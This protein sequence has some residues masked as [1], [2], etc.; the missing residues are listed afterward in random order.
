MTLVHARYGYRLHWQIWMKVAF[1]QICQCHGFFTQPDSQYYTSI[2]TVIMHSGSSSSCI[3]LRCKL[4]CHSDVIEP[5]GGSSSLF[6]DSVCSFM[7]SQ[8][9]ATII[10]EHYGVRYYDEGANCQ[11]VEFQELFL[12]FNSVIETFGENHLGTVYS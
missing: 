6:L 11:Q 2:L 3:K 7:H 4:I 10:G 8:Q 5:V 12:S 9:P 1:I